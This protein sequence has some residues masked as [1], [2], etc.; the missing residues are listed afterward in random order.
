MEKSKMKFIST[1]LAALVLSFS[2]NAMALTDDESLV[3]VEAITSGNLKVVKKYVEADPKNVNEMS[4][5][6]T[7]LQMAANKGQIEVAKYLLS[8]GADMNYTHPLSKNTAFHLAAFGGFRDMLTLLA[9][10]GA[11][12]NIKLKANVSLIRPFR[13]AENNSMIEFLKGLGVSEEG[14]N[15][16]K[17]FDESN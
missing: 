7:P 15:D 5:A 13:D 3:Y 4:F 2:I 12:V 8:K 11:D 10:S 9:K 6:W 16:A 14:C 1:L 17:C